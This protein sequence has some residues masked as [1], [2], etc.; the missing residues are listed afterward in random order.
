M[1]I[2]IIWLQGIWST[3]HGYSFELDP[4]V[5]GIYMLPLTAG[6]LIVGPVS[7]AGRWTGS[8]RERSRYRRHDHRCR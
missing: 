1:F 5:G 2:L 8:G 6:F 7:G 3:Q 4:A